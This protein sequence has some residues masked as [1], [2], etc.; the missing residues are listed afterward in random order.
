MQFWHDFGNLA[1]QNQQT[2]P[3]QRESKIVR[4]VPS[5]SDIQDAPIT[6]SD[7]VPPQSVTT[8]Q[9]VLGAMMLSRQA[10]SR[11]LALIDETAFHAGR[12]G[13]R[14]RNIFNAI[15]DLYARNEPVDLPV[16]TQELQ[17][18]GVL[19]EC[20]G[21]A[22]LADIAASVGTSANVE[23]HARQLL[24]LAT[25]RKTIAVGTQMVADSYDTSR[26]FEEVLS[27][28]SHELHEIG[29]GLWR[30]GYT[31]VSS[32]V[33]PRLQQLASR[34]ADPSLAYGVRTGFTELDRLTFGLH[35][36]DL[37]LVAARPSVGKTSLVLNVAINAHV[38]IGI[39][40]VEM[41]REALV[42]RLLVIKSRVDHQRFR[43]GELSADEL[44]AIDRAGEWLATSGIAIDDTA[45]QQ[46]V[47]IRAKAQRLIEE[48]G[49]KVIMVDYLQLLIPDK[50]YG[51]REQEV[52]A[53]SRGL[54][55]IAHELRIPMLVCSQLN[56]TPERR[57]DPR[58]RLSDLRE[59]GA[60]EAD[61]DVVLLLYNPE[62]H[63]ILTDAKTGRSTEGLVQVIV[64]KQRNG[65]I[66][67]ITL[68]WQKKYARFDNLT[69]ADVPLDDKMP[70]DDLPF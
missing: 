28:Y 51:N 50:D 30:D 26:P 3:S 39:V 47:K 24:E 29:T 40:S 20:G 56:R 67:T 10:I 61:A 66:G 57:G 54:K 17:R 22:Y 46:I 34:Q 27:R 33:E 41:S 2:R 70:V 13:G 64:A 53:I 18:K 63:N 4:N 19:E 55:N 23:Y 68:K 16:L 45:G 69:P 8:E 49:A 52:S 59:S 44:D 7:R 38:P 35:D 6:R 5:P 11:V 48:H 43:G 65:P 60:Q 15:T 37:T 58:P 42:D 9:Q 12:Y 62:Y 14:H 1:V 21:V 31:L 25:R 32:L 36:G